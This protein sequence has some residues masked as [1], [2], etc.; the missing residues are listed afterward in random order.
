MS[1]LQE[2][3]RHRRRRYAAGQAPACAL[4]GSVAAAPLTLKSPEDS[5]TDARRSDDEL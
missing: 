2:D 1:E 3:Q 5:M 4:V